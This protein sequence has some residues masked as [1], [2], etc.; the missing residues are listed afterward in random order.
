MLHFRSDL[1]DM[2]K[3][4]LFPP[5]AAAMEQQYTHL[6]PAGA[7]GFGWIAQDMNPE[8]A[9]GDASAGTA[10]KGR[11]TAEHQADG[12]IAL[13]RDVTKFPLNELA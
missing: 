11:L 12:F 5:K 4:K 6:R 10:E 3:A 13:L 8:G 1:V 2:R 7:H 9:L